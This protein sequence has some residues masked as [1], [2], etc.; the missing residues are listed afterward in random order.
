MRW[1]QGRHHYDEQVC[2]R[3]VGKKEKQN[4]LSIVKRGSSGDVRLERNSLTDKRPV[5][6]PEALVMSGTMLPL[7]AFLGLWPCSNSGQGQCPWPMLPPEAIW[8]SLVWPCGCPRAVRSWPGPS[9]GQGSTEFK[10]VFPQATPKRQF[11]EVTELKSAAP[12]PDLT[13]LHA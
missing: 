5:K 10:M 3:K 13:R 11:S 12:L 9:P 1:E 7:R 6:P 8:L 4:S 2:G